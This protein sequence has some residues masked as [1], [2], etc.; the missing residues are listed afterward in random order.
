MRRKTS[1]WWKLQDLSSLPERYVRVPDGSLGWVSILLMQT[2]VIASFSLST[3]TSLT[4]QQHWGM[5]AG[6]N[7]RNSPGNMIVAKRALTWT[8]VVRIHARSRLCRLA[9][10]ASPVHRPKL[11]C[12]DS[13]GFNPVAKDEANIEDHP[14]IE[15]RV[16]A[17]QRYLSER[18]D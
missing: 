11:S 12:S 3:A 16:N 6:N 5:P 17:V 10:P 13:R 8:V 9:M 15:I 14:G 1:F 2:L 7:T 18:G 4:G